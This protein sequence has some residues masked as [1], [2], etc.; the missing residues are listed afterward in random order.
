MS[1][2][3]LVRRG[4]TI[5][6]P[7]EPR[8]VTVRPESQAEYEESW[9]AIHDAAV[10]HAS[11]CGGNLARVLSELDAHT[12][13]DAND[14]L[15]RQFGFRVLGHSV[16]SDVDPRYERSLFRLFQ[17][18]ELLYAI[19][20]DVANIV[21]LGSGYGK[22]LFRIWIN[23]G[24]VSA[25]YV[26]C[27]YTDA[28]RACASYLAS[29]EQGIRFHGEP[30]DYHRPALAGFD[31]EAKT[32]VFSS[33]SIEQIPEVGVDVFEQLL[34]IPGLCKVVHIEPVGWQRSIGWRDWRLAREMK[35]SAL[36]YNYNRN[37]FAVLEALQGAG[38]IVIERVKHNFL[39]HRPNL[40]GTVITWRPVRISAK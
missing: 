18:A 5:L 23:G 3:S 17:E 26:G 8:N 1:I 40:P 2:K 28:G 10:R 21:E 31:R 32:F 27:E 9:R 36:E 16:A 19:D 38:R 22:N 11:N 29:L 12:P 7:V 15:I 33:Y 24:P 37:L 14:V 13:A 30:F 4:L 39:A 6:R 34:S 25:A 35:R 20:P